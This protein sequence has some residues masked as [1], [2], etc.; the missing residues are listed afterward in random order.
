MA[1][2][3]LARQRAAGMGARAGRDFRDTGIPTPNPIDQATQPELAQAWR[4]AYLAVI[5]PKR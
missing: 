2:T 5:A 3:L 1:V 4:A